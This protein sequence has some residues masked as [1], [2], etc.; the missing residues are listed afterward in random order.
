MVHIAGKETAAD[1]VRIMEEHV[2]SISNCYP[3]LA[4]GVTITGAAGAWTL[5]DFV[6]I[7][8]V[9]TITDDFDIHYI[10]VEGASASDTYEIVLYA[11]TTEIARVRI[12]F[13]DIANSMTLPSVPIQMRIQPDGTQIQAKCASSSGGSDT[14]K[15]SLHY[16]IY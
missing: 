6:E 16:H 3:T 9:D 8:P 7:V 13:I 5:G 12:S 4:G 11:A 14:I 15:I 1:K 10:T 2:H